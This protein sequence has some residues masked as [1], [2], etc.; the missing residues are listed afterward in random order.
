MQRSERTQNEVEQLKQ[1][2][3]PLVEKRL[4]V[5]EQGDS[6]LF[7]MLNNLVRNLKAFKR[8]IV[9]PWLMIILCSF[10]VALNDNTVIRDGK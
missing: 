9:V 5:I 3:L 2:V 7:Q 8:G 10:V 1:L 4:E 6:L